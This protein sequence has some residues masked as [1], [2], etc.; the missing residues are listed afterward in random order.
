MLN[1]L[2]QILQGLK[3]KFLTVSV[4]PK[5]NFPCFL[6]PWNNLHPCMPANVMYSY[7]S[8]DW[9]I[10]VNCL[11]GNYKD[12]HAWIIPFVECWKIS[13]SCEWERSTSE[14]VSNPHF[15]FLHWGMLVIWH[16]INE[17]SQLSW[18][19]FINFSLVLLKVFSSFPP[20]EPWDLDD[21]WSE[22]WVIYLLHQFSKQIVH[23]FH[24]R[25]VTYL[26]RLFFNLA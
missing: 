12:G 4:G 22:L 3:S 21:N 25:W 11:I 9:H 7:E 5:C 10:C 26:I 20:P 8:M 15:W 14:T 1:M 17:T 18:F 16:E 6:N 2:C 19:R 23:S 13:N 24:H